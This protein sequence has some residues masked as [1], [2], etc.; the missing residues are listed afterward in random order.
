MKLNCNLSQ[1]GGSV[2]RKGKK[3]VNV[4]TPSTPN[5][6]LC[7]IRAA[8]VAVA[9]SHPAR[10]QM[11]FSHSPD[12]YVYKS[13]RSA[14]ATVERKARFPAHTKLLALKEAC[15]KSPQSAQK[16]GLRRSVCP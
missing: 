9:S 15:P 5:S 2:F 13:Q 4:L 3:G 1:W 8:P 7:E 11:T 6:Y 14:G 12:C 10:W 16:V